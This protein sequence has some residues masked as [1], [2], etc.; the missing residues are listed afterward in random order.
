M[1]KG[2]PLVAVRFAPVML[3]EIAKILE[4]AYFQA[5]NPQSAT[6][7]HFIRTAVDAQIKMHHRRVIYRK[8]V[9]ELKG[10]K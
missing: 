9:K 4:L 8:E 5:E 1:S 10:K 2:T 3:A 6:M 7:S